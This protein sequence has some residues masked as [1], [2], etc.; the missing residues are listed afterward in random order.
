MDDT[1]E[2]SKERRWKFGILTPRSSILS[3]PGLGPSHSVVSPPPTLPHRPSPRESPPTWYS[4][5]QCPG[6]GANTSPTTWVHTARDPGEGSPSQ[7][8]ALPGA[9]DSQLD[10]A[11]PILH[12]LIRQGLGWEPEEGEPFPGQAAVVW[13]IWAPGTEDKML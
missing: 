5:G 2:G 7:S 6:L 4:Q 12:K 9:R 1:M 13:A 10:L 3:C 8:Y 11:L